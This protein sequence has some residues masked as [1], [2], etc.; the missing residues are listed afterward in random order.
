M[1]ISYTIQAQVVD[2]TVDTPKPEDVFLVD[3]NVWYWMTYTRASQSVRAPAQ[4]QST[5]YPSYTN[6]ALAVGARIFQS[7]LTLAELTHLIE[8]AEF[9]IFAMAN[10]IIFPDA[11]KFNKDFRHS[12]NTEHSQ[13][14]AEVQAAWS[15]VTALADP[16]TLTI[17]TLTTDAALN[18]FQTEKVDGYDLF[19]LEAMKNHGVVQVITDDGDF[20]T[21]SG[22]QVFT[23]NR[24]VIS[25]ARSQGKL[26]IR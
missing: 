17:D 23:A 18:R 10:P 3:T 12:Y 4:Y 8:R 19:I 20:T 6:A 15:Q 26:L 11:K 25:A 22:I 7:G 1:A 5:K 14:V 13:V 2:I 9:E 16:L 21:V 24:N